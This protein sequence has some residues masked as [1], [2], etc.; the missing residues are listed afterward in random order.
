MKYLIL[1]DVLKLKFKMKKKLSLKSLTH[2][3]RILFISLQ[4]RFLNVCI[5]LYRTI[6]EKKIQT[7]IFKL[8]SEFDS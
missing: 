2:K 6:D 5:L 7:K 3:N 1:T 4:V 8:V